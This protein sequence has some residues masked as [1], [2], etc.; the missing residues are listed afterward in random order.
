MWLFNRFYIRR[1]YAYTIVITVV[2]VA[3]VGGVLVA[4]GGTGNPGPVPPG[5]TVAPGP[6]TAPSGPG[7]SAPVTLRPGGPTLPAFSTVPSPLE[8]RAVLADP[9]RSPACRDAA[10]RMLNAAAGLPAGI[11]VPANSP[12]GQL[13]G[14]Y[15][16]ACE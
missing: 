14:A 3:A 1:V 6:T 8:L 10:Q 4:L 7:T 15:R 5:P 2:A 16:A 11:P 9:G 13:A 12:P